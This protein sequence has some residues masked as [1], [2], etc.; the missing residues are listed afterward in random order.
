[1]EDAMIQELCAAPLLTP[2]DERAVFARVAAGDA[3][4]RAQAIEANMRLVVNIAKKY[5]GHGLAFSDLVQ[6]GTLGLMRAVDG[7]EL[8]RGLRFSTYATW[9]IRQAIQRALL[10]KA[11][12]IRVPVHVGEK[13]FKIERAA[14]A[15]HAAHG[16]MPTL[17]ELSAAT[18]LS[19]AQI[20]RILTRVRVDDS[21][22]APR[23]DDPTDERTLMDVVAAPEE[24]LDEHA[25]WADAQAR[26]LAAIAELS[27][28][29]QL[30]IRR[31]FGFGGERTTLD[32]VGAALGITRE[33]V[34]QLE[35]DALA[36]LR[37]RAEVH[38]LV[39]LL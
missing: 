17:D 34:R 13:V 35:R 9:W 33:R 27:E 5:R 32:A 30:I 16:T 26:L 24:A 29:E 6:E 8:A 14:A 23:S 4:A 21:L 37:A 38:G 7:F 1:M 12:T 2:A 19:V 15:H 28:R 31:R 36:V 11:D 25:T 20:R 18:G 3:E 22:D 39:G 10:D